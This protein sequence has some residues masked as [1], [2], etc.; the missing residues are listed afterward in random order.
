MPPLCPAPGGPVRK[1]FGGLILGLTV[2]LSAVHADVPDKNPDLPPALIKVAPENVEDLKA[3][4]KQVNKVLEKVL[5]CTVGILV[6]NPDGKGMAAGSGVIVDAEGHVLTAGHVSGKPGV[7]CTLI[8]PDG[9]K[10]KGKTLGQ[11]VGIDSGMIKIVE[12]GKWPFVETGIS[13][14]LKR[15]EWVIAVGHPGGFKR[16][17]TPVVRLGRVLDADSREI[18]TDCTLVGGD[19]GGPLFDMTGKLVGINSRIGRTLQDNVHVPVD[20]FTDTWDR[21]AKG[22]SWGGSIFP[23]RGSEPYLGLQLDV[24]NKK[25]CKILEVN[26]NTPAAKAGLKAGDV[27]LKVDGRRVGDTD[28]LT[29]VLKDKKPGDQVGLEIKRGED[30]MTLKLTLGKR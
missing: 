5:P 15:G 6:P 19:S 20:T 1:L 22:E 29:I 8:F 28:E 24:D 18:R 9:K 30:T 26:E 25:E 7:D 27:I 3:I 14:D 16:G 13:K 21:L 12:E 17:R 10:V 11:N 23:G 4:Q 2:S